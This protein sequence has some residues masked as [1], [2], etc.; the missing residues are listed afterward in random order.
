MYISKYLKSNLIITHI[1]ATFIIYNYV[2]QHKGDAYLY[3]GQSFDISKYTWIHFFK[4]GSALLLLINYPLI[5]LH[6][7]LWFGFFMYS[8]FGLLGIFIFRKWALE[9]V[10]VQQ[11]SVEYVI[12]HC[13]LLFPNLHVWTSLLGKEPIIFTSI[14]TIA[15][16]VLQIRK[17]WILTLIASTIIILLRPHLAFMLI[18]AIVFYILVTYKTLFIKKIVLILPMSILAL[19]ILYFLTRVMNLKTYSI[20]KILYY[21]SISIHNF[22]TIGGSF[23]PMNEYNYFYKWF[24]LNFR[25]LFYDAT[26]FYQILVSFENMIILLLFILTIGLF[27]KHYRKINIVY[28][29]QIILYFSIF[30][31]IIYSERYA[32]LGIFIRTKIQYIPF[33]VVVCLSILFQL[34]SKQRFTNETKIN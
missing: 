24:S 1:I 19:I 13:I 3:W 11:Q 20:S 17:R 14:S 30:S 33:L 8:S 34:K 31:T 21:N 22:K 6:V 29:H 12:L 32:N 28:W 16:S 2:M 18:L 9:I 26:S 15:Y 10:Q 27:I 4:P 25:P 7:P 23:V 5:T